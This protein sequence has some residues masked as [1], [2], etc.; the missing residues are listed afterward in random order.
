MD[1]YFLIQHLILFLSLSVDFTCS[2]QVHHNIAIAPSDECFRYS[3]CLTLSQLTINSHNY[4][5]H[6]KTNISLIFLL[7]NH[8]LDRELTLAGGDNFSM[9]DGSQFNRAIYVECV[10]ESERFNI[11]KITFASIEGLHFIGC[12][13]NMITKVDQLTISDTIFQGIEV[14]VQH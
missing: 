12:G 13:G 4:L 11:S 6:N 1:S 8:T 3:F 9:T 14:E 2:S 5:G 7:G 10:T